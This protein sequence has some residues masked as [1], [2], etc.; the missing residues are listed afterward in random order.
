MS[1]PRP[2]R[3]VA[4]YGVHGEAAVEIDGEAREPIGRGLEIDGADALDANGYDRCPD[5]LRGDRQIEEVVRDVG[6]G[7]RLQKPGFAA[8]IERNPRL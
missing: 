2:A 5:V 8:R 7:A 4:V 1:H 3:D 6:G